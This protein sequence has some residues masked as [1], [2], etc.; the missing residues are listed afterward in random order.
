MSFYAVFA[1]DYE[2]VFPFREEVYRFL[3]AY[4]GAPGGR[5]LDVGCGPGHYCGRFA[6]DGYLATGIDLDGAM[7]GEALRRYPE[8]AFRCMDM[9]RVDAVGGGFSCVYS[10]G[11]VMAYLR[12]EDFSRYLGRVNRVLEADGAWV[13]QV[14]H[15]DAFAGMGSYEFPVK[16]IFRNGEAATFHRT[17]RFETPGSV[18]FCVSLRQ[19]GRVLFEDASVLYPLSVD[20]YLELHE[21]SGFGSG[22]VSADFNGSPLG[23]KPGSGLV[24]SFRKR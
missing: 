16:A 7:I 11:N 9:R 10:I 6:A 18:L 15:W 21:M 23:E 19:A 24:M 4:A 17:Y 20:R 12:P 22:V 1:A 13:M 3:R 2:L 14:M 5:V 8:A